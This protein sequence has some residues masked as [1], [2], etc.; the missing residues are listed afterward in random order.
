MRT[1]IWATTAL[2]LTLLGCNDDTATTGG[3]GRIGDGSD[4]GVSGADMTPAGPVEL[5]ITTA[6]GTVTGQPQIVI[7]GTV[8]NTGAVTVN[9]VAAVVDG[10]AWVAS[11]S[12]L[13]EGALTITATAGD[14]S[15]TIDVV[16]DL[17]PPRIDITG[18]SRG[19]HTEAE[20]FDLAFTVTESVSHLVDVTRDGLPLDLDV[21]HSW[22]L[23]GIALNPGVSLFGLEA[24]DAGGHVIQEHI[25]VLQG[26]LRDPDERVDGAL[27]MQLG[28]AAIDAL[29][30]LA[31][32]LIEAQNL[33]ELLPNPL[34]ERPALIT[35]ERVTYDDLTVELVPGD[36]ELALHATL[37]GMTIGIGLSVRPDDP[38]SMINV[39]V[40][41]L[42]VDGA[43]IPTIRAGRLVTDVP[44]D[45][46]EVSFIGLQVA[47]EQVPDFAADPEAEANLLEQVIGEA[48]AIAIGQLVPDAMDGLLA[49]L[50]EPIDLDLLGATLRLSLVPE[51]VLVN[52]LGLSLIIGVDVGLAGAPNPPT[53]LAGY[54]TTPTRWNGVPDTDQFGLAIDDDLLNAV[55]FALWRSGVLL[56]VIDDAYITN[57][58]AAF[59]L[60]RN[61]LRGVALDADPALPRETP[62]KAVTHLPLPITSRF[63][64]G[65][66]DQIGLQIGLGEMSLDI[67]TDDAADRKLVDGVA[68]LILDTRVGAETNAEDGSLNLLIDIDGYTSAFDVL[69]DSLRGLPEVAIEDRVGEL[70]S[71]IGQLLPGLISGINLPA[72]DQ[73][74][75]GAVH[76][77]VVPQDANFLQLTV[78]LGQ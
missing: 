1:L 20:Q 54:V 3:S 50:D 62:L 72:I 23:A 10:S 6:A 39:G 12:G 71:A 32:N 51:V 63:R 14:Q 73:V 59:A 36:G 25:A 24:I 2:T 77:D 60:V 43:L 68:S 5:A 7:E 67:Y 35:V 26:P 58:G 47:L 56:P 34:L 57:G 41:R 29:E 78:Q 53:D 74:P 70:L 27:R 52:A 22:T 9:G 8:T 76:V 28:T 64:K 66:D 31:V 11:L 46:V 44:E 49:R 38:P 75:L 4:A 18:P 30:T 21:G 16:V 61:L 69:D 55:S 45:R 19:H 40:Q 13:N 48:L 65:D 15:A 42:V 33:V 17:T 37:E